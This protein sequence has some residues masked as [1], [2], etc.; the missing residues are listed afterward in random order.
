MCSSAGPLPGSCPLL[1]GDGLL[2]LEMLDVAEKYPMV[3]TAL[4]RTPTLEKAPSPERVRLQ[5]AGVEELISSISPDPP[6]VPELEG[7][8]P[9]QDLALVPR[10]QPPPPSRFSLQVP[11]DLTM[12]PLEDKNLPGAMILF[13]LC[14]LES[15]EMTIS[16]TLAMG[17]VHYHLQA[18]NLT[19]I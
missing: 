18:W 13:D 5:M 14:G 3:A 1:G 10:R 11:E 15:L 8:V 12:V 2:S 6:S 19:R 7:V 9:P 4:A 16:H 17:E